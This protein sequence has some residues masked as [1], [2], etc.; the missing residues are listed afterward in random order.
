MAKH[1]Y[2]LKQMTEVVHSVATARF[3]YSAALVP[4]TDRQ[5][6]KLHSLWVRLQKGAWR[7]PP[8]YPGA[9]FFFPEEQ[10]G[11]AVPHPKVFYLQALTLHVEQ[12][13]L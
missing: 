6:D 3:R 10:G 9:V 11:L 4:W 13:A 7:L 8:S 2:T 1:S 5:L 12:L